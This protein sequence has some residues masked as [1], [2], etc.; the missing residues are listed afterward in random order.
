[1]YSSRNKR[2]V[3][4]NLR[5]ADG[6]AAL[7]RLIEWADVYI[8]N[9]LPS[10]RDKLALNPDDIWRVNPVPI[11]PSNHPLLDFSV[12]WREGEALRRQSWGWAVH[13]ST[14]KKR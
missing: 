2:G 13:T 14:L 8:T 10:A 6:R 5:D 9:F 7:D 11:G 3:A 1:M 4:I 12:E